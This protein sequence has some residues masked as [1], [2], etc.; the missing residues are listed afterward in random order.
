MQ[1]VS[2]Q[3]SITLAN[4]LPCLDRNV[5]EV[6]LETQAQVI[7]IDL[8]GSC[9]HAGVGGQATGDFQGLDPVNSRSSSP[10][11]MMVASTVFEATE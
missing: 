11:V 10:S 3:R 9:S 6:H 4:P 5:E 8:C 1:S 2:T 7:G